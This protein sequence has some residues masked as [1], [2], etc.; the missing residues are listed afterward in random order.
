[1]NHFPSVIEWTVSLGPK[2]VA[3]FRFG[4]DPYNWGKKAHK[5]GLKMS[6]T[7]TV[8]CDNWYRVGTARSWRRK[9]THPSLPWIWIHQT[10]NRAILLRRRSFDIF[11]SVEKGADC[12]FFISQD[13]WLGIRRGYGSDIMEDRLGHWDWTWRF[14]LVSL[15]F[16]YWFQVG[17]C[18]QYLTGLWNGDPLD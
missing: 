10:R 6:K 15:A 11:S 17:L 2:P 12:F 16:D 8:G 3:D 18:A 14:F 7:S 9:Y 1:M 4:I 5:K 13:F